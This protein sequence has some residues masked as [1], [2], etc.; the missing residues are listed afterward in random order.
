M[1]K[2]LVV[3]DESIVLASMSLLL[4]G[5]GHEITAIEHSDE[6]VTLL[7][8]HPYDLLITDIRMAPVDGMAL[9][10]LAQKLYPGMPVIVV[11]AYAADKVAEQSFAAGCVAYITKPF[12][13][14]EVL[15]AIRKAL[16]PPAR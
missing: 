13:I 14:S 1:A 11:S 7:K 16:A 5:E 6:A 15:D 9:M 10:Q 3:D 4:K 8:N 12:R 2:I